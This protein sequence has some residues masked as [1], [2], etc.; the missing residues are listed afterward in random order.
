MA[1]APEVCTPATA[2][3]LFPGLKDKSETELKVLLLILWADLAGYTLPDDL[4]TLEAESACFAATCVSEKQK[5]EIEVAKIASA[6]SEE[7][8]AA[9]TAKAVCMQCWSPA[10]I[11]AATILAKCTFWNGYTPT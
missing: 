8:I 2:L 11:D 3:A 5:L 7:S 4:S 6:L 9:I 10:R 1:V